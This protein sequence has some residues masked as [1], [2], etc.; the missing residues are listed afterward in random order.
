MSKKL[1]F[2][3][4]ARALDDEFYDSLEEALL[5]ADVGVTATETVIEDLKDRAFQE[6]SKSPKTQR[7]F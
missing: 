4:S 2:A 7:N 3:F 5:A 1:F 6:K